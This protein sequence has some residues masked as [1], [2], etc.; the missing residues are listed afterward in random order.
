M[1]CHGILIPGSNAILKVRLYFNPDLDKTPFHA[2]LIITKKTVEVKEKIPRHLKPPIIIRN[3]IE[4]E[5]A[6]FNCT[7]FERPLDDFLKPYAGKIENVNECLTQ[8]QKVRQTVFIVERKV[9][10]SK[11]MDY[12]PVACKP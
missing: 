3:T 7:I 10:N 9:D 11:K 12:R 6:E 8:L 5:I 1:P 2:A 4:R